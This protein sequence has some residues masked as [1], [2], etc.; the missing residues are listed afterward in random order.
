MTKQ[1][2]MERLRSIAIQAI[3]VQDKVDR[4]DLDAL[5]ELVGGIESDL[6]VV[7]GE[8]N[9]ALGDRK[10]RQAQRHAAERCDPNDPAWEVTDAG[11]QTLQQ[12][13]DD[14]SHTP[15]QH[16]LSILFQGKEYYRTGKVGAHI[17]TGEWSA[18]YGRREGG[19]EYRVWQRLHSH[20]IDPD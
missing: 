19:V 4:D 7:A 6:E 8:I 12:M 9:L 20:I 11:K 18:E 17:E 13:L 1:A 10:D 5:V 14:T 16:P 2:M 3:K 15:D